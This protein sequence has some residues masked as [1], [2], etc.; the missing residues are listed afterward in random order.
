MN[1]K[2]PAISHRDSLLE[3]SNNNNKN[4]NNGNGC[5]WWQLQL[6]CLEND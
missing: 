3:T 2:T 6:D 4:K 1:E 5:E